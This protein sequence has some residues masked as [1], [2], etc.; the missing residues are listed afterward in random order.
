MRLPLLAS[1]VVA[2]GAFGAPA[3]ADTG[4]DPVEVMARIDDKVHA[5]ATA[6]EQP[7]PHMID[8]AKLR[9][10][11]VRDLLAQLAS[12][13]SRNERAAGVLAHYPNYADAVDAALDH[14]AKLGTEVHGADGVA[15]R[16]VKDDKALHALLAQKGQHP[17]ADPAKDRDALTKRATEL[18][19]TWAPVLAGLA[20]T[21][22][23]ITQDVAGATV[24][25]TDGY[26]MAVAT[27]LASDAKATATTWADPSSAATTA[28]Q[29]LARGIGHEDV[30]LALAALRKR[31]ATNLAA[32]TQVVRDYNAWLAS[33]RELRALALETRDRIHEALCT[34]GD[35]ELGEGASSI[36]A[37]AA[38]DLVD[39]AP[40]ATTEMARLEARA[41]DNA[42]KRKAILDGLRTTG[43]I[44]VAI[45]RDEA[46]G[47]D[48]PRL[49]AV[50][51]ELHRRRARALA[52]ASC[53]ARSIDVAAGDC[54]GAACRIECMKLVE[55][56]CTLVELSPDADAPRAAAFAR[57]KR[58]VTGL[59]A[60]YARD[61]AAL[62]ARVPAMRTCEHTPPASL[63][64]F[65]DVAVYA[66]CPAAPAASLGESLAE[67][68]AD[69]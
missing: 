64:L 68:G 13:K 50:L 24:A 3:H 39:R 26:W 60:W 67:V 20:T 6:L 31:G 47:R 4:G 65:T 44:V 41:G 66:A 69:L 55:R 38:R 12:I 53:T 15:D 46:L 56:T 1:M 2:A 30:A 48:N 62:F 61:K 10:R 51:A 5:I 11:E 28:C 35:S 19:T 18:A 43:A 36:A 21:D 52:G 42:G 37:T 63:E 7:S 25:L 58:E 8:D 33:V 54:G 57:G 49:R 29:Q 23:A 32:A 17:S 22:A 59:Q 34:A 45:G 16:C 27:N 9:T 14:L 40:A